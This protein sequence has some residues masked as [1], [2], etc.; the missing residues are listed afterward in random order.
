MAKTITKEEFEEYLK[1]IGG[2][3]NGYFSNREPIT[4]PAFFSIGKGWYLLVKN[5]IQELIAL[6]WNK[7][8]LQVKEKFGG[9]RFYTNGAAD[10]AHDTIDKF[11][12][13][14]YTICELCGDTGELYTSKSGWLNTVCQECAKKQNYAKYDSTDEG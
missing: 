8:I 7:E 3:V 11:E 12:I 1:S 4:Y 13:L 6:K 14:S 9:L 5:L 2:L 10:V